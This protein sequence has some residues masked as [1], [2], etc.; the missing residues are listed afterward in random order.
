MTPK[1]TWL[2]SPN[3][4]KGRKGYKPEAVVIHIMEG[5]LAGTDSWFGNPDSK[6]SAHY[7]IGLKGDVHQYVGETDSAWHAGRKSNPSWKGIVPGV[8]PNYYTIGI[9]HEGTE[10][11]AWT[12]EMYDASA[13]LVR[14]ICNRW[15]IPIDRDHII[16]HREIYAVKTCPGNRV[17]VERLVKAA[18]KQSVNTERYNFVR[19]SEETTAK[20]RLNVRKGAPT[21]EANIART[22]P[23]GTALRY[24]GWTS[25][26]L[27]VNGNAHWYKDKD[28]NYFWAGA[29][30]RTIPGLP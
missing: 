15:A 9:E 7:G 3:K 28:G 26:G 17:D 5:T 25:N 30:E 12:K 27:N 11:S 10:D 24:V 13:S 6:V 20:V 19:D 2:G 8:N 22:I 4:T 29:T 18:R 16:G 1:I 21:T 23:A 14:D